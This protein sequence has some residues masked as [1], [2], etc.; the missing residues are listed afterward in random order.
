MSVK[1]K[2]PQ[3]RTY[4]V[5]MELLTRFELVTSSLPK[6][7]YRFS[8]IFCYALKWRI[9]AFCTIYPHLFMFS[10]FLS[11]CQNNDQIT[12][13]ISAQKAPKHCRSPSK[14]RAKQRGTKEKKLKGY[15]RTNVLDHDD[16]YFSAIGIG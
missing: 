14:V 10:H 12:T 15:S 1:Q 4:G 16:I 2:N 6:L 3:A 7:K 9:Y 5:F 8:V 11:F 13:K